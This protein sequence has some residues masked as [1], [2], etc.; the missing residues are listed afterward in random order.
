MAQL[1]GITQDGTEV[2]VQVKPDGRL[3]AEGLDGPP[4]PTGP[5]GPAG[6]A[7]FSASSSES[8]YLPSPKKLG[9][10]TSSPS[11]YN[12]V[13]NLVTGNSSA[14]NSGIALATTTNGAGWLGFNNVGSSTIPGYIK[15]DFTNA[16]STSYMAFQVN[17]SERLRIDGSGNV[18]IGTTSPAARLDVRGSSPYMYIADSSGA[19]QA[20][21]VAEATNS[22]V[23]VG[24]TY[25]GTSA[26]PLALIT[27]GTERARLTSDGKF[28][29]GTVNHP[30]SAVGGSVV[31]AGGL[32]LSSPNGSWWQ[33]GVSDTGTLSAVA[34]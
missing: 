5:A 19:N 24:S 8:V 7:Q 29:V 14:A 34:A 20:G 12:S 2:P 11:S 31:C 23:N 4:G 22:V 32:Y 16:D 17:S 30:Q 21:F 25:F 3:V 10:G 13:F 18:G 9:L 28:L 1:T 6:D 15:Y 27:G 33:I 26:V